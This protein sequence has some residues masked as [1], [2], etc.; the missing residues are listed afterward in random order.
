M[1]YLNS[2]E[3]Y[4]F[5]FF[6][7]SIPIH[8]RE[9]L[10][11]SGWFFSEWESFFIYG[12]DLLILIL[13]I[14]WVFRRGYEIVVD[15]Y[16]YFLFFFILVSFSS[17]YYAV[18]MNIAWYQFAK[19]IEF[20]LLY[21]YL[22]SYALKKFSFQG[23]LLAILV[24]GIFQSLIVLL[25]YLKQESLGLKWLGESFLHRD[26]PGVAV[27]FNSI[28]EKILRGY[29]TTP[30]P[31]VV[32]AYIFLAIFALYFVW[33]YGRRN[34]WMGVSVYSFL[35]IGLYLTY[36]RTLAAL[37]L[38]GFIFRFLTTNI[39]M[40]FRKKYLQDDKQYFQIF[41]LIFITTILVTTIFSFILWP[42]VSTR[43]R[44]S[45]QDEAVQLRAFYSK[46]SI[47]GGIRW[48]GS[49][50]GNNVEGLR[51]RLPAL[52][53]ELYQPVHNI[54]LIILYETGILGLLGFSLFIFYLVLDFI[55]RHRMRHLYHFSFIILFVSFLAFGLVDHFLWSL[56]EGRLILWTMLALM[57]EKTSH[58]DSG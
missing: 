15:R 51:Q 1:R 26:M 48:L 45:S 20:S 53:R 11:R 38:L 25:Q 13:L 9:I 32:A 52:P 19:L 29:G 42:E 10:W 6:L 35:I 54:Y 44:I 14:I 40:R 47:G 2:I 21:F 43:I 37:F 7:F 18:N 30:H 28:G 8:T 16:D 4:I 24:G 34:N 39:L 55:R 56:Q 36:S 46:E 41:S 17:I 3:K 27:F 23:G 31:N 50:I 33:I 22:K 49:G 57:T 58:L 5:Y 12:T